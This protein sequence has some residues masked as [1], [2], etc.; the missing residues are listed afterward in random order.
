[1]GY[2][3]QVHGYW[4]NARTVTHTVL[5]LNIGGLT[6][7]KFRYWLQVRDGGEIFWRHRLTCEDIGPNLNWLINYNR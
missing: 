6:V 1:M 5:L 3:R 2:G 4:K 7:G